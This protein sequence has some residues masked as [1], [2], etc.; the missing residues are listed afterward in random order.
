MKKIHITSF[1][2]NGGDNMNKKVQ[3][4]YLATYG[5]NF[6]SIV[7]IAMTFYATINKISADGNARAFLETVYSL[8][9]VPWK[10]PVYTIILISVFG[11]NNIVIAKLHNKKQW[12]SAGLMLFN[13][14]LCIVISY[15]LNYSYK[16]IFLLFVMSMFLF[17]IHFG[18]R[19]LLLVLASFSFIF[20]DFDLLHVASFKDYVNYYDAI[21]QTYYFTMKNALDS[22]SFILTIIF[23]ITLIQS[24]I[25]ENKEYILLN[26]QLNE[27]V[28]ELK[29]AN[30]KLADYSKLSAENA[31]AKERNRMAREIHDILGHSLTSIATGLEACLGMV[32]GQIKTQL[33]KIRDIANKGLL[34]VRRSVRELKVDS[35]KKYELVSALERLVQEVNNISPC[36]VTMSIEGHMF[37]LKEDEEKMIYRI[38]QESITNSLRHGNARHI[39]ILIVFR[40][41]DVFIEVRDDGKGCDI[42]NKGFGLTHIEERVST[43][44]GTVE[45]TSKSGQGFITRVYLPLSYHYIDQVCGAEKSYNKDR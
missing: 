14:L 10:V 41:K 13:F 4:S 29:V 42:I 7:F 32:E 21:T 28:E 35:I 23:F 2:L 11:I 37:L 33:T 43:F 27:K 20:M 31:K 44:L 6:I 22:F 17:N 39:D 24:K 26:S 16:G 38:I 9:H 36:K 25:K 8:P 12:L 15:Y 1:V 18:I 45:F 40:Q 19:L 34:D 5:L 30:A 3:W